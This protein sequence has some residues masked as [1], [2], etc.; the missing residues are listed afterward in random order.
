MTENHR[1][2][3]SIPSLT[4]IQISQN[5]YFFS[6]PGYPIKLIHLLRYAEFVYL[7]AH[8]RTF[9]KAENSKFNKIRR[10]INRRK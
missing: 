5:T 9:G 6:I 1:V 3:G 4:T 8:L 2:G 10:G 7:R